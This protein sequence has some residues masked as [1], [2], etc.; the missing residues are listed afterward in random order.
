MVRRDDSPCWVNL[1][2]L[3][4][5]PLEYADPLAQ[6]VYMRLLLLVWYNRGRLVLDPK[7]LPHMARVHTRVWNRIKKDVLSQFVLVDGH[8]TLPAVVAANAAK[9][10]QDSDPWISGPR[11]GRRRG[12]SPRSRF[13]I[14]ERDGFR[15]VYCG[16]GASECALQVDHVHPVALGGTDDAENLVTAC[17]DCNSG[18]TDRPLVSPEERTAQ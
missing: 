15:C 9:P 18:K 10:L 16:R 13:A 17:W 2:E 5:G 6:T 1:A 8:L 14:L 12:M 3:A 11:Q 7:F 4:H